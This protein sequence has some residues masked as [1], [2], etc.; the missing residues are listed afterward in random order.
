MDISHEQISFVNNV[1]D[2]VHKRISSVVVGQSDLIDKLITAVAL[3]SHVLVEGL[4]GLA[5]TLVVHLLA[6]VTGARFSRIQFTPDLLPSDITGTMIYDQHA[7][8]FSVHKGPVFA[9]FVIAD[10]INRA[11]AKVHSALLQA[12]EEH[13]VSIGSEEHHLPKPFIVMATQNP[14]EQE[15][16]YELPEAQKDR[17]LFKLIVQYPAREE[18]IAILSRADLFDDIHLQSV[19]T[20]SDLEKIGELSRAVRVTEAIKTYIANIVL[21]TRKSDPAYGFINHFIEYGASPRAS[22]A[23]LRVSRVRA[24]RRGRDYVTPEDVKDVVPD[25]LRHRIILSFDAAAGG[26]SADRVIQ[27]ILGNVSVPQ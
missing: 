23:I 14:I 25:I 27:N 3:N 11:P 1:W 6:Q 5:K 9:N 8:S 26:V 18:E 12:M 21:A 10:E 2:S 20:L 4:P 13:R 7:K 17:F 15:G 16:T 19:C 22:L 24:L